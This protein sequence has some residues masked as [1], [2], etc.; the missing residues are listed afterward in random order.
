MFLA[1]HLTAQRGPGDDFWYAPV[2]G[3]SA[4]AARVNA[5]TAMQ[6]STVYKCVRAISE[7]V[8]MLPLH[9]YRRLDRGKERAPEHPV[10]QLLRRPNRWQTSMQWLEMI[11]GHATLLGNGYSEIVYDGRG[12]PVE[13]IPLHPLRTTVEVTDSGLPR[14]LTRDERGNERTLLFG[15]VLHLAGFA[16]DGYVGLNPIEAEREAIAAGMTARDFGARFFGNSARPPLWIEMPAGAKFA[17]DDARRRFT[18]QF[19]EA[20]AGSNA[21]KAPVMDQGMKLH[22]ITVSNVDSQWLES[23]KY[24]DIDICGLWRV[25][26]HK[27]GILDRA[28]WGNIEHQALEWVTDCIMPWA[29]RWELALQRDLDFGDAYF[30]E[31]LLDALLRGDTKTRYEAYGKG[32]ND[33][34]LMRNEARERE[35]LN[36]IDGLDEPAEPAQPPAPPAP[37]DGRP[38]PGQHDDAPDDQARSGV[39]DVPAISAERAVAIAMAAADRVAR[40]ES[41]IVSRAIQQGR[42]DFYAVLEGHAQFVAD[43]MGCSREAAQRYVDDTARDL[44]A[45]HKSGGF[46]GYPKAD[47]ESRQ[48]VRLL[49]L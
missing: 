36:P 17:D 22:Q 4:G 16:T 10:A 25:P 46:S 48:A 6:L 35:N 2:P 5:T 13:L 28:T 3:G 44:T 41:A 14:Y 11:Q 21:G 31:Y 12:M 1:S 24:S 7:T 26:P 49:R 32:I 20:Y 37:P 43:V 18:A 8:A 33:G 29:R 23:R 19:H 45:L 39:G 34:W 42:D 15:Q 38:Q 9:V 40:K 30:P 47:Y 27:I